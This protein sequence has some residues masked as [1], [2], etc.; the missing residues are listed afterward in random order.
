MTSVVYDSTP[1]L[2]VYTR[3]ATGINF[4]IT[5]IKRL[6]KTMKT[7]EHLPVVGSIHINL[8]TQTISIALHFATGTLEALGKHT[9]VYTFC[10]NF[11]CSYGS[12]FFQKSKSPFLI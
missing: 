10:D 11:P 7:Y 4:D 12:I 8:C 3:Q 9:L 5:V 6:V 2:L 1:F